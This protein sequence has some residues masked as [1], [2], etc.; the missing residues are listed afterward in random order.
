MNKVLPIIKQVEI[1]NKK[2]FAKVVLDKNS[3]NFI[4]H[5]ASLNLT[6]R[7]YSGKKTQITF[8]L[9]KKVKILDEYSDFAN[10]FSKKQVLILP[11]RIKLNKHA[12]NLEDGK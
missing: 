1:I 12:I 8:L 7:I 10:I 9:T 4:I 6:S 5:V 3:E 11:E 2:E